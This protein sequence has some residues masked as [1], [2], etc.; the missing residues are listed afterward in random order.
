MRLVVR[1]KLHPNRNMLT[2]KSWRMR[3]NLGSDIVIHVVGTKSDLVAQEPNLR[4]VPFERCIAYVS[5]NL[6]PQRVST[7]TFP[8]GSARS[9]GFW[10][11]E[12]GTSV[13]RKVS[14][15]FTPV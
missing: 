11:Q 6:Y 5:E 15:S 9:S 4:K 2:P 3:E 10:G 7:P 14:L 12:I 8:S 13:Q 1:S